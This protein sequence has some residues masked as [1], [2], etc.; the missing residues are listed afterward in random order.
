[1]RVSHRR[2]FS[3]LTEAQ[4]DE[5]VDTAVEAWA[6]AWGPP[7]RPE[8]VEAWLARGMYHAMMADFR[9]C[10]MLRRPARLGESMSL[11]TLLEEWIS[12]EHP[13]AKNALPAV[14]QTVTDRFL[15]QLSPADAR[16]LWMRC[17]GYTREEIAD[18]LGI[19]ANAV[20]VRLRRLKIRLRETLEPV[21][22]HAPEPSS[23]PE[24]GTG[25]S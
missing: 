15:R 22:D 24:S 11:D 18:L 14:D 21:T 4:R 19:R 25:V 3:D 1:M 7:G 5:L 9:R 13:H 20:G 23:R 17:E 8:N 10:R 6:F 16:L 2:M 12:S